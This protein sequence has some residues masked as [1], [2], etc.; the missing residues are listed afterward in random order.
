MVMPNKKKLDKMKANDKALK[1]M[2]SMKEE[3]R[4][5]K[6]EESLLAHLLIRKIIRKDTIKKVAKEAKR[7]SEDS[8]D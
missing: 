2:P 7:V 4:T 5:M 8:Q 1:R 6:K 3:E